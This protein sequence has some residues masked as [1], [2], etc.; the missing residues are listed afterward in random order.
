MF[1]LVPAYPG[2]PG[3]KA[4]K[5]SLLL[6]YRVVLLLDSSI[7]SELNLSKF[8]HIRRLEKLQV[9]ANNGL[10][11]ADG[12]TNLTNVGGLVYLKTLVSN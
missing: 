4:V 2:C 12:C 5:R 8:S 1:L 6:Y 11:L 9:R 3:S 7:G 10:T